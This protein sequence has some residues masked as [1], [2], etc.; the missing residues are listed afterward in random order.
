MMRSF[1]ALAAAALVA[2]VVAPSAADAQ[3]AN[4]KVRHPS[5]GRHITVYSR[6]SWLTA[7]TG[8]SA[9]EFNG[10]ALDTF[11]GGSTTFTPNVDHTTVGVRGL[12]R[13]PNNYTLPGCCA[14]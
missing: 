14:P 11:G 12:T 5:D 7:G 8:A 4:R 6:E 3:S 2:A 10:Y 13:M 1:K 9:G